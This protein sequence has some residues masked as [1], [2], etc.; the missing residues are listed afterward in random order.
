MPDS[1]ASDSI[2]SRSHFLSKLAAVFVSLVGMLVLVGWIADISDFKSVYGPITMKANTAVALT[3]GGIALFGLTTRQKQIRLLSQIFAIFIAL[4]GLATLTEHLTGWKLGIDELLFREGPGAI[5]TTSPGRMGITAATCLLL[6][7]VSLLILHRSG[8]R[9]S[10]A[11]GL[12]LIGG[13]WAMLAVVGYAYQA[14]QLYAIAQYTGI[15]LHT[16]LALLVF[17]LGILVA[18]ID[19][20]W[21][22]IV[23][24]SSAA[25]RV[26]RRLMSVGIIAPFILGWLLLAGGR[27]G[28]FG[29]GLGTSL[30]VTAIIVVFVLSVWA[31]ADRLR[32]TEHQRLTFESIAK[33]GEER[34][35]RQAALID[36]SHEPIF[37]WQLEGAIVDWNEGSER[38]YGFTK[39]EALG[40]VSHDLLKTKFSASLEKQIENL[41]RDHYWSG[42]L[43]HVT[44]DGRTVIVESK[45]QFIQSNGQSL[46]LETNRDITARRQ[47]EE[48]LSQQRELLQVTLSSIGDGVIA[49]DVD[50][51]ITFINS[52]AQSIT[53][54]GIEA[55]GRPVH[56]VFNI[57]N[58]QTRLGVDNPALK[59]MSDGVIVGLANHTVLITKDGNEI[60]ID[61][62]GA[63][64][65]DI[66]GRVLGA[67]LIFRDVTERRKADRAQ[68]ILAEIVQSS[69]DAIISKSLDGTIRSWNEGAEKLFGYSEK[70][71]I[72]QSIKIIIPPERL[73]E[74]ESILERLGGGE[75]IQH[76]ETVRVAKDGRRIPISLTVSPVKNRAGEI[77]GASKI[78]RDISQQKL[79]EQERER[80]LVREQQLRTEA[81]AASKLKDEFLATVSHELRTPLNAILG[82]GTMLR[83]REVPPD[84]LKS[85]I[86]AIE[87]NARFQA[88]LIE[89]LLDVSRIIS[90][91]MRLDIKTIEI[92]PI[93]KSVLESLQPAAEAKQIH[94]E[95]IVDPLANRLRA[96]EAR[97]QQ[98]IWNLLSNSVKFTD[99]GGLITIRIGRSESAIEIVVTDNGQGINPEF[100]PYVFDRFQQADAS[101]TRKHGGLG[102]GLAISRHLVELHG[103][104]I[105]VTSPGIG[106]GSTFKVRLPVAAI[107]LQEST[108][109]T[110]G[111][112]A[113]TVG[114]TEIPNLAQFK[115]LAIDDSPD[116]RQ[117]LRAVLEQFGASV[118]TASSAREGLELLK[119]SQP[120][121]VVCD[122]GMPEEDGYTFISEV[123]K[124]SPNHGG[125]T[126][127]IALTAYVRVEDRMRALAA[128]YQMFVA[129]PVEA[130][131]LASLIQAVI[132]V[133]H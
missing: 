8:R 111:G 72:G 102:L 81:Q 70:E 43:M 69:D 10:L 11:Q 112:L 100:L 46:V 97:L 118:L 76:F 17:S 62:S 7:G 98:I 119:V 90:G 128:G 60:P 4:V 75:R 29:P 73:N 130:A 40:R 93:I 92:K 24:D 37:V 104:T 48:A 64:I 50:G 9:V 68:G 131:E 52:M 41:R 63:P 47:A 132:G 25:G 22:S 121:V 31:A 105:E 30:L 101:I 108:S 13:L 91:K 88:Q 77:I 61:D 1:F 71:V 57:I 2:S 27:A 80:L 86:A 109:L 12:T 32:H 113:A 58:E 54:W 124:L 42:E 99:K 133:P 15:A 120:D 115:V 44:K 110:Q 18:R 67:V 36:L 78:A 125:S 66:D 56:E 94:L 53:G 23:V 84:T 20:G 6:Y 39:Q 83:Q 45:Q 79:I 21:L 38:L 35:R 89:D 82:W 14:E 3:L 106:Q 129:K 85:G 19:E 49:T 107:G 123:R 65:R 16:A 59:A 28:L 34:I 74:E 96:D 33:E 55:E 103:G 95:M 117:L 26:A 5:A 51:K 87:R 116:A 127:A 122:I 114:R 126:P